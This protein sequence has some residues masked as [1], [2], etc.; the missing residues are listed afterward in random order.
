MM[1]VTMMMMSQIICVL[2]TENVK[3][4]QVSHDGMHHI[5]I[6]IILRSCRLKV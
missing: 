3:Y 6:L 4:V 2:L 1:M 5:T